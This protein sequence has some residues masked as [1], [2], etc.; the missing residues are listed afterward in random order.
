ML[1]SL[2]AAAA[3][4]QPVP[5]EQHAAECAGKQGWSDPAPPIR[6]FANVFDVGTCGV[7]V[8]LV[9]GPEG[10]ILIDAATAEAAPDVARNIER[11]G[12]RLT[13]IKVMLA[14]HEHLDHVGGS[15]ELQRRTG[16]RLMV[17]PDARYA[18]E[19]GLLSPDDPQFGLYPPFPPARVDAVLRDGET[20][21]VGPLSLT[22]HATFGHVRGST[23]WTWTSC[24]DGVC[25]AIA[26]ADSTTAAAAPGYRFSDHPDH[27]E[28]FRASLRKIAQLRCDI[29][30]TPHPAVSNLYA[31]LA[32]EAPLVNAHACADYA[33]AALDKLEERLASETAE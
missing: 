31:R 10:H 25:R 8:L 17:M 19:T 11:L 13:D 20:V 28:R 3:V 5:Y 1:A 32:G 30:I 7:V 14:S 24:E 12:F 21:S 29:L 9:T 6:I 33:A 15:A 2:L 26:Y 16:A 23:S 27:V 18:V 4:A 22:A